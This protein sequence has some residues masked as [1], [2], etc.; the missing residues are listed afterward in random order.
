MSATKREIEAVLREVQ[1]VL[2]HGR[3]QA[4]KYKAKPDRG[5]PERV[6]ALG[7]SVDEALRVL[8]KVLR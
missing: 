7:F 3:D 6:G 8:A 4:E 1:H 5:F 2:A